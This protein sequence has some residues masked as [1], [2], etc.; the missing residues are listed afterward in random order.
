MD[1][2]KLKATPVVKLKRSNDRSVYFIAGDSDPAA[3]PIASLTLNPELSKPTLI[4]T[5]ALAPRTGHTVRTC[6]TRPTQ[7]P[8]PPASINEYQLWLVRQRQV[9][10]ILCEVCR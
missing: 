9:Y 10:F 3:V 4:V 1:D 6:L 5:H 2:S 7:P 8:I